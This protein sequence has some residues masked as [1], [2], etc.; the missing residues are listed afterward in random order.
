MLLK[1][2]LLE[3]SRE[4]PSSVPLN[5]LDLYQ[6]QIERQNVWYRFPRLDWNQELIQLALLR[7]VIY[8]AVNKHDLAEQSLS[9]AATLRLRRQPTPEDI[10]FEREIA[11]RLLNR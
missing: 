3:L 8:S 6:M 9:R 2:A 10:E 7:Y 5:L 11:K 4:R 1:S